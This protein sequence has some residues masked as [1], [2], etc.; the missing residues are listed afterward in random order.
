M[1]TC[2]GSHFGHFSPKCRPIETPLEDITKFRVVATK[3]ILKTA[4]MEAKRV[5]L[6]ALGLSLSKIPPVFV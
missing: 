5:L 6:H 4:K 2:V 1:D 3:H